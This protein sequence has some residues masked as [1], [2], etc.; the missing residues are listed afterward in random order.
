M[1]RLPDTVA[2]GLAYDKNVRLRYAGTDL[3]ALRQNKHDI[4]KG[5]KC[6]RTTGAIQ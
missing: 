5:H 3:S 6:Q 1:W 2:I 4:R